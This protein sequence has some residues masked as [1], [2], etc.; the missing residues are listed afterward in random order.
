VSLLLLLLAAAAQPLND[1]ITNQS[2]LF[3]VLDIFLS[4]G[5]VAR[6]LPSP[7]SVTERHPSSTR[8]CSDHKTGCGGNSQEQLLQQRNLVDLDWACAH[9]VAVFSS[10]RQSKQQPGALQQQ[11]KSEPACS[12]QS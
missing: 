11:Q 10:G 4:S 1:L 2:C 5:T 8:W 9:N 7:C 12:A 6:A 3:N